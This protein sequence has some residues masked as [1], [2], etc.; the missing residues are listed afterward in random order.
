M[1]IWPTRRSWKRIGLG[2]VILVAIALVSNGFMAWW[3]EHRLQSRIAAI[4]A[5]GDPASTA[6][7]A[8]QPVAAA[9]NAAAILKKLEPRLNAY[10]HDYAHFLD[11]TPSGNEYNNRMNRGEAP[12]VEQL[13]ALHK[14]LDRYA[15]VEAGLESA[16]ACEKYAS[17]ADFSHG[18]TQFQVDCLGSMSEIR[19]AAR[20]LESRM[21]VLTAEGK[22]EA[23]VGQ[24]IELLK[25][26]RLYDHEPAII[27]LLPA[28]AIRGIA[29]ESI[30]DALAAGPVSPT[31]HAA[32]DRELAL[33]DDAQRLYRVVKTER[34]YSFDLMKTIPYVSPQELEP[35]G[36]EGRATPIWTSVVRL[37]GW[38]MKRYYIGMLDYFDVELASLQ[39]S[40]LTGHGIVGRHEVPKEPT[41]LGPL[42]ELMLPGTQSIYDADTR[43][44]AQLR[45]LRI[46]NALRLYAEKN[47]REAAKLDDLGLPKDATIDPFD[48]KPLKLKKTDKGWVVYS[49]MVNGVDDGGDFV[50]TK[51]FGVAPRRLRLISGSETASEEQKGAGK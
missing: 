12:T 1:R 6:D 4:R 48:G 27:N 45:A 14:I 25:L 43:C 26:A 11:E 36:P 37:M 42:A 21:E 5:A 2:F 8:P 10:L 33:H 13:N 41:G 49:V 46:F 17:L 9:E 38:P 23:A 50:D 16:A 24:G 51:D 39:Q 3:T 34:A 47:G 40:W 35:P 44:M 29:A 20:F 7:L 15:D 22:Q 32:L 28:I 30:Y 18:P 19:D 31:A